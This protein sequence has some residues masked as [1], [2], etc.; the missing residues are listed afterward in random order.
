MYGVMH[1]TWKYSLSRLVQTG[2]YFQVICRVTIGSDKARRAMARLSCRQVERNSF[3]IAI[4]CT[5]LPS[6]TKSAKNL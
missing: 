4:I 3:M 2:T 6:W 1:G 5:E